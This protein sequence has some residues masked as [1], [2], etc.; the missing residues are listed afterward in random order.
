[1]FR[2]LKEQ[3]EEAPKVN[4]SS[5]FI[6]KTSENYLYGT[7]A[8]SNWLRYKY[9]DEGASYND[10]YIDVPNKNLPETKNLIQ[11]KIYS[12]EKNLVRYMGTNSRVYKL[13]EK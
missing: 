3:L 11:S 4:W 1:M 8:Q 13:W 9:N 5:R 10:G 12:P 7:Y 2:T 6:S